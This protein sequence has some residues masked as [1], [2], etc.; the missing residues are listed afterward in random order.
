M[1]RLIT[2]PKNTLIDNLTLGISC[3]SDHIIDVEAEIDAFGDC[4]FMFDGN[5][6][7]VG[8]QYVVNEGG[9]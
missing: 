7:R 5:R 3:R 2:I 4:Y 9:D 6:F 1:K 8:V